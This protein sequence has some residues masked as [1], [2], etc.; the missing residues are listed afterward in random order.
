MN[1]QIK[2]VESRKKAQQQNLRLF[3]CLLMRQNSLQKILRNGQREMGNRDTATKKATR[4]TFGKKKK[5]SS[6]EKT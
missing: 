1:A 5:G 4:E 3:Q 6:K 2:P